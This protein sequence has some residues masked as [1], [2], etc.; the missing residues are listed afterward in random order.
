MDRKGK[1]STVDM[2]RVGREPITVVA[3]VMH[4]DGRVL[5]A[6]RGPGQRHAGKWE[7]PGGKVEPGETPQ[8][9]LARELF[10]EFHIE[11]EIAEQLAETIHNYPTFSIRLI[12]FAVYRWTGKFNPT[13]HSELAWAEPKRISDFD[14][15]GADHFIAAQL[16]YGE[17]PPDPE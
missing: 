5:V 14:L 4:W 1:D 10:E 13:V 2:A 3:A 15:A 9:A 17:R 11:A 7:F 16:G 6:R 8:Q 12:A